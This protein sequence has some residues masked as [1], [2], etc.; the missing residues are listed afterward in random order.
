MQ[1]VTIESKPLPDEKEEGDK[2]ESN[3]DKSGDA[4]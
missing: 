4:P 2:E 3:A 1:N